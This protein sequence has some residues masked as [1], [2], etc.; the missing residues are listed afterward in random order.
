MA[1]V[2]LVSGVPGAGKST[3][4]SALA[5][6]L[7]RG[8]HIEADAL[9]AMIRNGARWPGEEPIDEGYRQLRL[10]GRNA[11]LLADSFA[12]AGFVPVVDDII[13]GNRLDE[14]LGDLRSEPVH[15]VMLAPTLDALRWRNA[16]REKV[17]VFHQAEELDPVVRCETRRV[18]LW[19]DTSNLTIEQTVESVLARLDEARVS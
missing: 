5:A 18:G 15:F 3:L 14:F 6:Q 1:G 4:A 17:D 12:Q 19:L 11:C 9:Q 8:V 16:E 7:E 10:R 2:I 13:V